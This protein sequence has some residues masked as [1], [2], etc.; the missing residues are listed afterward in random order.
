VQEIEK[1]RLNKATTIK[2]VQ[3][4]SGEE[5]IETDSIDLMQCELMFDLNLTAS[6]A[7]TFGIILENSVGEKFIIGY[8]SRAKQVYISRTAGG[9]STFLK[10]FSGTSAA[11]Y[12][13]GDVLKFHIF[14]DASSGELFVD[15][16]KLVMTTLVFP[17]EKF[18]V[19]KAF[20]K[21]GELT[22]DRSE[23]HNLKSI[24]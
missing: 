2:E 11:P 16:G 8:S 4:I 3:K 20:S 1:L 12:R 18:T 23:F 21:G 9:D 22:I 5:V 24:W 14:M 7:D 13:A 6:K 10:R 19:L 15:D 17:K